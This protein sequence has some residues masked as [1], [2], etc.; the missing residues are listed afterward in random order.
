M[1]VYIGILNLVRAVDYWLAKIEWTVCR[2]A[3]KAS[4]LPGILIDLTEI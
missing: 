2:L 3:T 1:N 4:S